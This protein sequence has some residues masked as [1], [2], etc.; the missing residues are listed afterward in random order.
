MMTKKEFKILEYRVDKIACGM[1]FYYCDLQPKFEADMMALKIIGLTRQYVDE[2]L[3]GEMVD[4]LLA[5]NAETQIVMAKHLVSFARYQEIRL[6]GVNHI[7][8]LIYCLTS[9]IQCCTIGLTNQ[10]H[11]VINLS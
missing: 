5:F 10:N 11:K 7:D 9:T 3:F 1:Q 4:C 6:T 2:M 8:Y